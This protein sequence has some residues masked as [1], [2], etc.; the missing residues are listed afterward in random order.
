[1]K[2]IGNPVAAIF[3]PLGKEVSLYVTKKKSSIS[4][5]AECAI[6]KIWKESE[7][8]F[9]LYNGW[10]FALTNF[11]KTKL[12]GHFVPY[13]Y[14]VAQIVSPELYCDIKLRSLGVSS[15]VMCKDSILIGKRP[16][17]TLLY[18]SLYELAPAGNCDKSTKSVKRQLLREFYEETG[19]K[20]EDIL[21]C[22]ILGLFYS[23]DTHIADVGFF[24]EL[25]ESALK[26][27]L[28]HREHESLE[29]WKIEKWKRLCLSKMVPTSYSMTLVALSKNLL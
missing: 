17:K 13:K 26:K 28:V 6:D 7:E 29:W 18:P 23:P 3:Y 5:D 24:I 22:Q 15:L 2:E 27:P 20:R 10:I 12:S 4:P 19:L 14:H 16:K 11:S 25:K 8:K 21:S 1:M 9:G